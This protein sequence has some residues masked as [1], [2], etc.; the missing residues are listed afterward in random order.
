MAAFTGALWRFIYIPHKIFWRSFDAQ[1]GWVAWRIRKH[2][3]ENGGD[4][5]LFGQ[6]VGYVLVR[7]NDSRIYFDAREQLS[8]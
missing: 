1:R 5:P 6:I 7:S 3:K 4:R 2:H 8:H